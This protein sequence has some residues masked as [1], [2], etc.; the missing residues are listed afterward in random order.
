MAGV[1]LSLCFTN[2]FLLKLSFPKDSL[3]PTS[4]SLINTLLHVHKSKW[5]QSILSPD[6][7]KPQVLHTLPASLF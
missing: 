1:S 2:F 6:I 7:T 4:T 3:Y 5:W